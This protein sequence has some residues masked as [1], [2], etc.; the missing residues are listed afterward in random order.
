MYKDPKAVAIYFDGSDESLA[1]LHLAQITKLSA[2]MNFTAQL[3]KVNRDDEKS[4]RC[5]EAA[6]KRSVGID[7]VVFLL[8]RIFK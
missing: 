7:S 8:M 5:Y 2:G 4:Q 1:L 3:L 6:R